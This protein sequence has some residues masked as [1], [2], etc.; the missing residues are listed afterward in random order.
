VIPARPLRVGDLSPVVQRQV[1]DAANAGRTRE[2]RRAR[3]ATTVNPSGPPSPGI[4]E[5]SRDRAGWRCNR[6][7]L[8]FLDYATA[9]RHADTHHG[10]ILQWVIRGLLEAVVR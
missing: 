2:V 5:G 1:A 8:H 10:G 4:R 9:Q 6:C 3:P 7:D